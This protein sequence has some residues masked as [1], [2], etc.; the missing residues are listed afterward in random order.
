MLRLWDIESGKLVREYEGHGDAIMAVAFMPDGRHALSGGA[1]RN[2]FEVGNDKD[3]WVRDLET[4]DVVARWHGHEGIID[5]LAVSPDGRLA[6]SS[7]SDRTARLWDVGTGSELKRFPGQTELDLHA[8]FT[9]DG[10]S[11]IV[12]SAGHLIR[13]FEV[14]SGRERLVLRGH[15]GKVDSFAASPDGRLL[16]SGSWPERAFRIWDLERGEALGTVALDANPQLGGF[17]P[18]GQRVFWSFSDRTIR[19]YAVVR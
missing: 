9:R 4:G 12:A 13:I 3:I 8:I 2:H 17:T 10:Q 14:E 16:I 11:A 5:A 1:N 18:D 6:L 15:S 19:E 7:A